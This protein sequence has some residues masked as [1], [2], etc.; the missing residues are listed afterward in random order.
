MP[1]YLIRKRTNHRNPSREDGSPRHQDEYF[2][3]KA[4]NDADAFHNAD[5]ERLGF[6]GRILGVYRR[7]WRR[8][9]KK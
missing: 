7:V 2:L 9:R 5:G 3:I 8:R 6:G 4:K 1:E